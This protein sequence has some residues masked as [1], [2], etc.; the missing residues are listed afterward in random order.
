MTKI[1]KFSESFGMMIPARMVMMSHL[2]DMGE[3]MMDG[4]ELNVRTNFVKFLLMKYEN[5]SVD[6]DADAE[7]SEFLTKY[8]Q[9]KL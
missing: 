2:S 4:R 6:I 9:F 8:P 1:L 5:T 3:G 7:W